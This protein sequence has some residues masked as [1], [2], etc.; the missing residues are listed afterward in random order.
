MAIYVR[1]ISLVR[2]VIRSVAIFEQRVVE[3]GKVIGWRMVSVTVRRMASGFSVAL[4]GQKSSEREAM[5]T[6]ICWIWVAVTFLPCI[7]RGSLL[8][9]SG[10]ASSTAQ[11]TTPL[12]LT[13]SLRV[14]VPSSL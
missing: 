10:I 6:A 9:G 14:G 4:K 13:W 11:T 2:L 1:R 5:M 12:L 8:V 3:R 7:S